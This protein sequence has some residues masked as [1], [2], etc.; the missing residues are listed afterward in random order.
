MSLKFNLNRPKLS[1]EEINK[2]R[3]FDALVKKFKAESLKKARG[4]ESWWKNKKITYSAII[5]GITV[6]CTV[7]Y[8]SIQNKEKKHETLITSNNT[9]KPK[10]QFIQSPKKSLDVPYTT[11]KVNNSTGGEFKH[12]SNT[13][14]KVPKNC[15]VDK[16]GQ[17]IVGEVS[18]QYREFNNVP[19]IIG[20]GIPMQYDSAG[21]KLQLQSAGMFDIKGFQNNEAV[22]IDQ[23]KSIEVAYA[24]DNA[25]DRFN[26]YYLDSVAGNWKYIRRDN[27][28]LNTKPNKGITQNTTAKAQEHTGNFDELQAQLP[29]KI[30]SLQ[31]V[32]TKK[33]EALPKAVKPSAPAASKPGRPIFQ[34]DR[35]PQDFPELNAF[36][37]VV[38]E[39][40]EENKNYTSEL[41]QVTWRDIKISEGPQKG[42]NYLLNLTAGKRK[43]S[44]IVYPVFVGANY[45]KALVLYKQKL[46][47]YEAVQAKRM[48]EEKKLIQEMELKQAAFLKA[49]KEKEAA[50]AA[51]QQLILEAKR[52]RREQDLNNQFASLNNQSKTQRIF[53]VFNFGIY[54]S[55]CAKPLPVEHLTRPI[56]VSTEQQTPIMPDAVY[57]VNRSNATVIGLSRDNGFEFG[58]RESDNYIICVFQKNEV[59]L[60]SDDLFKSSINSDKHQFLVKRITAQSEHLQD[61]K[62]A[63]NL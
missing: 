9:Q 41:H 35:D 57:L 5:A 45:E 32:Y 56:F 43:E 55:D 4:D 21:Q 11:Y 1:D 63:L 15:F 28:Q 44:L 7:T 59:H 47:Q 24:S 27:I 23:G 19:E 53:E 40:G 62:K 30:D 26:Q 42:K 58:Y 31:I 36:D 33:I 6:V 60:C 17:N 10:Q 38:F 3:D 49:Q 25:E 39:V 22:F 18:I 51:Q 52:N 34:I 48:A 54:N 46:N 61:F 29:K 20:S 14:I 13:K 37:N 2:Q 12:P 50:L 16:N 8:L